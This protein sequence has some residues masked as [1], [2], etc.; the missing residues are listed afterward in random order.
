M[1]LGVFRDGVN[2]TAG[3]PKYLRQFD[4]SLP[5]AGWVIIGSLQSQESYRPKKKGRLLM[6]MDFVCLK[7]R[8]ITADIYILPTV[9]EICYVFIKITACFRLTVEL[10]FH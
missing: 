1:T 6:S 3:Q 5:Q 7:Q 10:F 9:A 8:I 2:L 4:Q